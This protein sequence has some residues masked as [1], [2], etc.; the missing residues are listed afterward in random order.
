M[1]YGDGHGQRRYPEDKPRAA[2]SS[3][4]LFKRQIKVSEMEL[5]KAKADQWLG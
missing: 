2:S 3:L 4:Q 5:K 1:L